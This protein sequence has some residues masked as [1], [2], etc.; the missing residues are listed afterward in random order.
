[1]RHLFRWQCVTRS[2]LTASGKG[3]TEAKPAFE[4]VDLLAQRLWLL[5]PGT[6]G[7]WGQVASPGLC[8]PPPI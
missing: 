6:P 2:F 4:N 7:P 5:P 1:M 8:V 3:A